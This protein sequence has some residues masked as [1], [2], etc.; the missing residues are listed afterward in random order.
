M[1]HVT[2]D[3][4]DG[5]CARAGAVIYFTGWTPIDPILSLVIAR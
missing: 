2:P 5:G 1:L 3:L 4:I